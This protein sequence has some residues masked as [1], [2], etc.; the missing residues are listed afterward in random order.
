MN[1]EQ[2]NTKQF[3]KDAVLGGYPIT[4]H[5]VI[6]LYDGEPFAVRVADLLLDP[7]AW[8]AVGK[9]RGWKK[10]RVPFYTDDIYVDAGWHDIPTWQYRMHRFIGALCDGKTI[11]EALGMVE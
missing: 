4:R 8:Q 2:Q 6:E 10:S 3:A 5:G 11:E 1:P 9:T 7:V